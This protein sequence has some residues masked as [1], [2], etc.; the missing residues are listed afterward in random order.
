MR[1]LKV[2]ALLILVLPTVAYSQDG[3]EVRTVKILDYRMIQGNPD[4]REGQIN[5][6]SGAVWVFNDDG[7]MTFDM[8]DSRDDLYPVRGNFRKQGNDIVF[9][10][11][12][13]SRSTVGTN[14]VSI[15]GKL[16]PSQGS[17]VISMKVKSNMYTGATVNNQKFS[18]QNHSEYVFTVL[19][20]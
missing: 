16:Y 7:S 12:S 6:I 2:L 4:W 8:P 15:S 1:L 19:I 9:S 5:R 11:S 14:D 10:G 20:R 13:Q 17:N 18:S 3:T